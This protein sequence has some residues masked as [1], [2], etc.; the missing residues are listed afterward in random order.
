MGIVYLYTNKL[1]GVYYIGKTKN[2]K[3]RYR[4]HSYALSNS[5]FHRAYYKEEN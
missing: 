3:K 5:H 1:N 4:D 2:P